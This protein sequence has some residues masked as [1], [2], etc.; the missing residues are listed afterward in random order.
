MSIIY[1]IFLWIF[2]G[3]ISVFVRRLHDLDLSGWWIGIPIILY[4]SHICSKYLALDP[5]ANLHQNT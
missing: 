4:Q 2:L 5:I 3:Y 1:L